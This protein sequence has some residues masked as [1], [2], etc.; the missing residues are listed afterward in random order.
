M[1]DEEDEGGANPSYKG[2]DYQ[3]LVTV[4]VALKLMFGTEACAEAVNIEPASHDDIK[5]VLNVERESA[6]SNLTVGTELHV[7]I[8]FRGAGHWSGK[9]FA[10]VVNEKKRKPGTRGPAPRLRAKALLLKEPARRYVFITNTSVDASMVKGRIL[11]PSQR[12]SPDF[13][14]KN[15]NVKGADAAS[16]TGR[17]GLIEGMQPD[18]VRL[19][20]DR[21]LREC[22]KIPDIHLDECYERLKQLV[23]DRLLGLPDPLRKSDIVKNAE[24]L[25]GLPYAPDQLKHYVAPLNRSE[26]D[27]RLRTKGA[28]VLVGPPGYGKSLTAEGIAHERRQANPPYKIIRETEGVAAIEKAL[29][30]PG[31][32]LFR[33]EDPWG[34]SNLKA[35]EAAAWAS[36]L[37]K[38]M[39]QASAEKLFVVTSRA[40]VYRQALTDTPAAV[41]T[42]R[43]VAIDERSYDQQSKRA[44]LSSKLRLAGS[45]R[46]DI[47][48][49]HEGYLLSALRSPLDVDSFA[50]EL[51]QASSPVGLN[52]AALVKRALTESRKQVVE[53]AVKG[54]GNR[55]ID[56]AASLWALLRYSRTI[57]ANRLTQLHR[58]LV[59]ERQSEFPTAELASHLSQSHLTTEENGDYSA[60]STVIEALEALTRLYPFKSESALNAAVSATHTMS[61]VDTSWIDE[62]RRLVQ[63][64]HDLA[65]TG[66][67]LSDDIVERVDGLLSDNLLRSY[68]D[69]AEFTTAWNVALAAMDEKS[70]LRALQHHLVRGAPVDKSDGPIFSWVPPSM[71][72]TRRMAIKN[73]DP[74]LAVLRGFVAHILP[75]SDKDYDADDLLPWLQAFGADLSPEFLTAVD[76]V[77]GTARFTL[78]SDAIAEGALSWPSPQYERVWKKCLE[79]DASVTEEFSKISEK[80]R[81]AWQGELDFFEQLG[82][83]EAAEE[84]GHATKYL[85][86]GYV[87]ARLRLESHGWIAGHER[88]DLILEAWADLLRFAKP[89][90]GVDELNAFFKA[91]GSDPQLLSSGLVAI[92]EQKLEAGRDLAMSLIVSGPVETF[93]AAARAVRLLD[94][95]LDASLLSLFSQQ[96]VSRAAYLAWAIIDGY[97]GAARKTAIRKLVAASSANVLPAVQLTFSQSL[98]LSEDEIIS[99]FTE[100]PMAE[101]TSLIAHGPAHLSSLLV[102]VSASQGIDVSEVVKEWLTAADREKAM[103][104]VATLSQFGSAAHRSSL[105]TALSHGDYR[106]RQFA[107]KRLAP[108]ATIEER[109]R[110]LELST[111]RSAP[112]REALA[113]LIGQHKWEDGIRALVDLLK[114]TRD[115]APH[116]EN[117]QRVEPRFDVAR[118]AALALNAFDSLQA[119]VRDEIDAFLKAGATASVDVF[120][121]KLLLPIHAKHKD[122]RVWLLITKG[123][124]DERVVGSQSENLYPFRYAAAWCFLDCV[125]DVA[126]TPGAA[127]SAIESAAQHIDAQLAGPALLVL[128]YRLATSPQTSSLDA[129]RGH[130]RSAA[131]TL[132]ALCLIDNFSEVKRLAVNHGLLEASHPLFDDEEDIS[133]DDATPPRWTI[134]QAGYSWLQSLE[135]GGD[136]EAVLLWL[137]SRRTGLAL[138]DPDFDPRALR[139]EDSIP[140]MALSELFGME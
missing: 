74:E 20:I 104:A 18:L 58:Q 90:P 40:E 88:Q 38:L 115:Y 79:L 82:T 17:F 1:S 24:S 86:K 91:V 108:A 140:L 47:A 97:T 84:H 123:L 105:A 134:S 9:D 42:T 66:V 80:Y 27:E 133:T 126:G 70:P 46:Q 11:S 68:K 83:Q 124:V 92:G 78:A 8:K 28:V 23:E 26:I 59:R 107:L 48:R 103:S 102:A 73:A 113:D 109:R 65:N 10:G 139:R 25:D 119:G 35:Q 51:V 81:Q 101:V 5:A 137:M 45:W 52:I 30:S 72:A 62:L 118:S 111:D 2:Y 87:R 127:W 60:H 67:K 76:V 39:P 50:R 49:E 98:S 75:W 99:A 41:W 63:G 130:N 121:H 33:L 3:K 131:R 7:Q 54:F 14:P 77:A 128:G 44:M 12:P 43:S 122:P 22:L 93:E 34:Q 61:L 112:V 110:L 31:R 69:A 53:E 16:L 4:W 135:G 117:Q 132:L 120:V 85:V 95:S 55:G 6:E 15:L 94:S 32:F 106:V 19:Q 100:L 64:A 36:S 21:Q 129:L 138:G 96:S 71:S 13:L 37:A 29:S 57:S 114:D 56:G 125:E 89:S 116:P 136:V